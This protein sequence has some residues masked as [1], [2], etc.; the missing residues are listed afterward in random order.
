MKRATLVLVVEDDAAI[1]SLVLEALTAEGY[2][3]EGAGDAS[4][5]LESIRHRRPD[6]II[7]DY[8]L[9][10][11][12]GLELL[13]TLRSEGY[14]DVPAL[15]VSADARP[16]DLPVT[17]FI[18]KPFDLEAILRAVRRALGSPYSDEGKH[19][20]RLIGPAFASMLLPRRPSFAT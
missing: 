17:S 18:P 5:A 10:V 2:D 4:D 6:L 7:T 12:D 1:R 20:N 13:R 8:H 3:A 16:P 14:G 19:T 11:T 9:P 15:V